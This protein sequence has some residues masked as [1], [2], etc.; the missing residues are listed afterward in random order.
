[1]K[2]TIGPF[3]ITQLTPQE[4]SGVTKVTFITQICSLRITWCKDGVI[5]P[6]RDKARRCNFSLELRLLTPENLFGVIGGVTITTITAWRIR[7][8]SVI[9][10]VRMA[11]LEENDL[12]NVYSECWVFLYR[13]LGGPP[14]L[15]VQSQ[16]RWRSTIAVSNAFLFHAWFQCV[17]DTVTPQS[18]GWA[19]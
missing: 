7:W 3:R 5:F 12:R 6:K 17:S 11:I 18:R 8:A 10:E 15:R 16:S 13:S 19:C 1:M 4:L 2:H 9:Q 14:Q